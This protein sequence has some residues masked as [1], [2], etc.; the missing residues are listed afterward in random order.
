MKLN[1][2][3]LLIKKILKNKNPKSKIIPRAEKKEKQIPIN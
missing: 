3:Y 2:I 1:P